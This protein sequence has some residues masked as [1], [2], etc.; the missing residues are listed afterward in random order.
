MVGIVTHDDVMDVVVEEAT[1]DAYRMGAVGNLEESYLEADFVTVWRKRAIWLACLFVAEL[2]TFT[3]MAHFEDS[4]AQLVVLGLF[5]P[6][7]L[8]TG[9]T[10]GFQAATLITRAMALGHIS[11]GQWR[12]VLGH[13]IFMGL[14]LGLSLGGI[15]L[16]RGAA[17]PE[18]T[19]RNPRTMEQPFEII[20]PEG[21]KLEQQGHDTWVVPPLAEQQTTVKWNN[22]VLASIPDGNRPEPVPNKV[23]AW[24]FP[25]KTVIRTE[26]VSRW[27]LGM[28]IGSAVALIC[29]WGTLIGAMLPLVFKRLGFDPGYASSPFVATFVDVTGI[30]IYFTIATSLLTFPS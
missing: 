16:L 22:S 3:A 25:E 10:P 8:S 30:M 26:A 14:A 20:L 24:R 1:E 4:I 11:L 7:C 27:D 21:G 6:L 13:E 29:L 19:R 5:V 18:D 17:T 12:K 9:A 23:G 15:G 2:F 28:V